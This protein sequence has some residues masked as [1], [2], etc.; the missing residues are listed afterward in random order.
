VVEELGEVGVLGDR[1]VEG[2]E[3]DDIERV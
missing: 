2:A 1:D 3:D